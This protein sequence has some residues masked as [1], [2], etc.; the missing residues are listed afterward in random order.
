MISENKSDGIMKV[1]L[2]GKIIWKTNLQNDTSSVDGV[3]IVDGNIVVQQYYWTSP[4]E[5]GTHYIVLNDNDGSVIVD[6]V[7]LN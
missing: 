1:G 3:Q 5:H 4:E 7:S 2:D 6:A